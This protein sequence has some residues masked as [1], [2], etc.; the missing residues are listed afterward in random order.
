ASAIQNEPINVNETFLMTF[1]SNSD[2]SSVTGVNLEIQLTYTIEGV[3]FVETFT[4]PDV[5]LTP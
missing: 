3:T 1:I 2:L 4:I 5:D